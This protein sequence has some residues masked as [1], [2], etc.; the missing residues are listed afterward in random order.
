M[1]SRVREYSCDR[2]AQIV[3]GNDGVEAMM[4]LTMGKHL[5]KKTDVVNYLETSKTV[6]GFWIWIVNLSSSHPILPKR[7]RALVNP[8]VHGKLF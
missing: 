7:I 3:S 1:L 6:K 4:A 5:Y 2:L 8:T